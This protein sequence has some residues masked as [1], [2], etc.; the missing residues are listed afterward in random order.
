[1]GEME[2]LT[3][4]GQPRLNFEGPYIETAV[5]PAEATELRRLAQGRVLEI[6]TAYGFSAVAMA[7]SGNA[8][9]LSVDS[10]TGYK[11]SLAIAQANV[12]AYGVVDR[13]ELVAAWSQEELPRLLESGERFDLVFVDGDH[14]EGAVAHDAALGWDLLRPGG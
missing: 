8:W 11:D 12:A 4:Q 1:M 3:K 6:G 5:D 10:H 13:I 7:D 14:S 2:A 9:V